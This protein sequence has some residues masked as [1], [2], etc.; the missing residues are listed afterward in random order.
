LILDYDI[1]IWRHKQNE[2]NRLTRGV[3]NGMEKCG[4]ISFE[5]SR[6]CLGFTRD[7]SDYIDYTT[8]LDMGTVPLSASYGY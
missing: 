3:L 1:S 5:Q 2:A 6:E 8:K 7:M 4:L